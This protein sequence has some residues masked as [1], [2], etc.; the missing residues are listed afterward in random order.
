MN[1]HER[2]KHWEQVYATRKFEEV[3]WYQEIPETS[4]NLISE[5]GL[6]ASA[7][8]IDVGAGDSYL[9][10][11]LLEKGFSDLHVLDIS[12]KALERLKLKLG[13]QAEQV[14]FIESDLATFDP[15]DQYDLWHD[16]AVL[17]F[18]R[19]EEE[20]MHYKQS[21]NKCLNPGGYAII[22]SFS[23]SGP[24]R[25]SG[26]EIR[27]YS[28]ES[29][30]DFLGPGFKLLKSF[31]KDHQTPSGGMQNFLFSVFRKKSMDES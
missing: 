14:N 11:Y 17:H 29:I 27:Q 7:R 24:T 5:L 4:L 22:G 9:P 26:L 16:R 3:S 25:C 2:K 18:L 1:P 13:A 28:E 12:S 10:H 8:I 6:R 21:L 15:T 23:D 19:S 30:T 31:R 20:V